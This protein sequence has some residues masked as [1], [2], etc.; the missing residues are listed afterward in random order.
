MRLSLEGLR[1]AL[2]KQIS[3]NE[4]KDSMK[5]SLIDTLQEQIKAVVA[6]KDEAEAKV[7]ELKEELSKVNQITI[8]VESFLNFRS[9]LIT[10]S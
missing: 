3:T 2:S 9:R 1:E 10:R 5:N 4:E 6:E 7:G 8:K